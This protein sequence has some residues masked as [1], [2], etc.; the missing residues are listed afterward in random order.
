ML[1]LSNA[2]RS[3]GKN[4]K[5]VTLVGDILNFIKISHFFGS[6]ERGVLENEYALQNANN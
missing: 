6:T 4:N 1:V 5:I 3:I 2:Y